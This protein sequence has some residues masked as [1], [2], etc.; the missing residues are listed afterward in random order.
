MDESSKERPVAVPQ[1][2]LIQMARCNREDVDR[3]I[4]RDFFLGITSNDAT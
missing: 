1:E 2:T 4:L 3:F